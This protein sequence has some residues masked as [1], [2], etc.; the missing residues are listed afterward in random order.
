MHEPPKPGPQLVE[1]KPT[2]EAIA[3]AVLQHLKQEKT[4]YQ[5]GDWYIE[6]FG[7]QEFKEVRVQGKPQLLLALKD[8]AEWR[9]IFKFSESGALDEMLTEFF[10]W[11][12]PDD[13][14][15]DDEDEATAASLDAINVGWTQ[16][17][18]VEAK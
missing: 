12:P 11:E 2:L 7:E 14:D 3:A 4:G 9:D 17:A 13:E 15:E 18:T 6:E 8:T 5:L 10:T 16:P 1:Q